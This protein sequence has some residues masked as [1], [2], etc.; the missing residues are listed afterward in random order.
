MLFHTTGD[1]LPDLNPI[2]RGA[3]DETDESFHRE[4]GRGVARATTGALIA[5]VALLSRLGALLAIMLAIATLGPDRAAADPVAVR[6]TEGVTRGF[7]VVS[8]VDGKPLGQ[9]D[10]QQVAHPGH[11]ES[12]MILRFR[13]GSL[14]DETVSY[15]QNKVFKLG[16]FRLIQKGPSFP[17]PVEISLEAA[18]GDYVV[19]VFPGDTK[20]EKAYRGKLEVPPDTYNGLLL[21]VLKNLP[22]G[23]PATSVHYVAFTPRPYLI[24][25]EIRPQGEEKVRVGEESRAVIRYEIVPRLGVVM[26]VGAA[27]LGK[28]PPHQQCWILADQVPAFV[29]C[30]AP[31]ANG[32]PPW[33]IGLAS[34]ASAPAGARP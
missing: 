15:T 5:G 34:P 3:S 25:L 23:G 28:T 1:T 22:L 14:H 24:A 8:A 16:R 10:I 4:A 20:R 17:E 2:A 9:G 11:V 29:G 6:F 32:G 21:T 19:T 13:D 27:I 7:L 30:E 33:R 18:S 12:R 31:L 26:R